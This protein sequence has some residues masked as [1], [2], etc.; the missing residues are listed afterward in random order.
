MASAPSG[1]GGAPAAVIPLI[2]TRVVETGL[3][4]DAD[5]GD[6]EEVAVSVARHP[7]IAGHAELFAWHRT[8]PRHV[9]GMPLF[10][11]APTNRPRRSARRVADRRAGQGD[12]REEGNVRHRHSVVTAA[13]NR[14]KRLFHSA[15]CRHEF[16]EQGLRCSSFMSGSAPER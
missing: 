13:E 11:E 6:V 8:S 12:V 2:T 1:R 5:H 9:I 3:E 10:K 16:A 15:P 14:A 4:P 7:S